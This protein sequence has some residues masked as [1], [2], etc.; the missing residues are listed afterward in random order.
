MFRTNRVA[1]LIG[2]YAV[3]MGA[4]ASARTTNVTPT[5]Q[6]SVVVTY[7]DLD[8]TTDAGARTLRE[9]FDGAVTR[10]KGENVEAFGSQANV[11]REAAHRIALAA[12]NAVIKAQ[13]DA[14][15]PVAPTSVSLG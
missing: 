6:V 10:I 9:R 4:S 1:A 12:A 3:A 8:L 14:A 13:R 2:I 7:S 15:A 11:E 5:A